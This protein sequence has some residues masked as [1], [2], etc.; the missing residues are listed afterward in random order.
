MNVGLYLR[1][2]PLKYGFTLALC[3]C[4]SACQVKKWDV[5][6]ESSEKRHWWVCNNP[7]RS[8]SMFYCKCLLRGS[9]R[10]GSWSKSTNSLCLVGVSKHELYPSYLEL[11]NEAKRRHPPIG[12]CAKLHSCIGGAEEMGGFKEKGCFIYVGQK[13]GRG[14]GSLGSRGKSALTGPCL[15][16][17]MKVGRVPQ[18]RW[19]PHW[20]LQWNFWDTEEPVLRKETN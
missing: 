7:C 9:F 20:I 14:V 1:L 16:K 4:T 18:N 13:L 2:F 15:T 8:S 10:P 11:L 12:N 17:R 6:K 5:S 3:F 19:K